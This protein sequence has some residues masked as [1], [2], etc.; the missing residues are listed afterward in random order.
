MLRKT[1]AL[2][3]VVV[4]ACS[5]FFSV[6]IKSASASET[7]Q[8]YFGAFVGPSHIGNYSLLQTFESA[9]GKG[10]SIWTWF[11][12]WN[13]PDDSENVAEFDTALMNECRAHGSIPMISWS[14]ESGDP[15]D[16]FTNLHSILDGS[17]DAYL[18]AW[19]QAAAAWGHPFFVR[20]MWEFTGSWTAGCYPFGNGNTPAIFVQAWQYVVNKVRAAGA[21]NINWVW[22]PADV[23]DSASTLASV[24]PGNAY[25][26]CVGTDVYPSAGQSFSSAAQVEISNIRS[27]T[28]KPMMLPEIGYAGSD[29][30]ALWNNVLNNVLPNNYPYISAIV[31]WHDP[32]DGPYDVTNLP[33]FQQGIASSYFSS[34]VFGSL[35]ISPIP[36]IG[37]DLN[38]S[39]TPTS[40]PTGYPTPT[41]SY[42]TPRFAN[43]PVVSF[44][45]LAIAV[46]I[47]LTVGAIV[48]VT[49]VRKQISSKKTSSR[50]NAV[51]I[52]NRYLFLKNQWYERS[53]TFY[54]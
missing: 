37:E 28:A 48:Y 2:F 39:P 49:L 21:T 27:I 53:T 25:V 9:V 34:N 54:N 32:T 43:V 26:D 15:N 14:P 30:G 35:N 41:T 22:C 29:A 23:G 33:A 52:A 6:S 13:R 1:F 42:S 7:S 38:L 4:L 18:T 24:Y 5:L 36:P 16:Q 3:L 11:Q 47:F 12:L 20:L 31:I 46:V 8:I 44:L 51:S 19:G 40:Q 17:Q 10:V 50:K 45:G